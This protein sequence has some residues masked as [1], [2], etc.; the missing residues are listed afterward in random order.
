MI[1]SVHISL[2]IFNILN[3]FNCFK[4]TKKKCVEK[5]YVYLLIYDEYR[6][7][8]DES[9]NSMVEM[10]RLARDTSVSDCHTVFIK[11][12]FLIKNIIISFSL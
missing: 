4:L 12:F 5:G 3:W 9:V 7:R 11:I 10:G 1:S 8:Q 2:Q 6:G